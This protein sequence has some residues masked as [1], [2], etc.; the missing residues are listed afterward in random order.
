MAKHSLH[1]CLFLAC[2]AASI[3]SAVGSFGA[4][5]DSSGV[6]WSG[7]DSIGDGIACGGESTAADDNNE[8]ATSC[9]MLSSTAML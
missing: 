2:E 8:D 4:G 5:D 7:G 6:P 1:M 9:A 3:S